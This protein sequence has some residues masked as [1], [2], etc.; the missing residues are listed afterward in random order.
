MGAARSRRVKRSLW[1]AEGFSPEETGEKLSRALRGNSLLWAYGSRER[2][3]NGTVAG[4]LTVSSCM[5][6]PANGERAMAAAPS[7]ALGKGAVALSL[8]L[9]SVQ[10]RGVSSC[11]RSLAGLACRQPSGAAP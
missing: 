4:A 11:V 10:S 5:P 7:A 1:H 3:E 2:A 9:R 6:A 8:H